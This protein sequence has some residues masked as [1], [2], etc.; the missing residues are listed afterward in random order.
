MYS[1]EQLQEKL[2]NFVEK[3][4][5]LHQP[6]N[7]YEP[8]Q[9]AMHQGGKRVRPLMVLIAADMFSN[10]IEQAQYPAQAIELLHNFTLIHD[11]IM[12][13]APLRRGKPT[14]YQKY[15]TNTAILSADVTCALAYEKLNYCDKEKIPA[16]IKTLTSIF[17]KVCEGQ[18]LDMDF[19]KRTDV[20]AKEYITMISLKT[21]F[22]IAGALKLGAIV[23]N[24]SAQNINTL[25]EIGLYM[26]IAFQLQD[27]V[28]D[29]WSDLKDFGKVAGTDIADNKKTMLY[30]NTLENA[31]EQD[32]QRLLNLYNTT[33][34]NI[35][36]KIKEVKTLF[37]KYDT[38]TK[39]E[40]MANDYIQK[41]LNCLNDMQIDADRKDNLHTLIN[42]LL[43]RNK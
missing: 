29:V 36:E 27:D 32:K 10:D 21:G 2:D 8:V 6:L 1:F 20:T 12:D 37:E 13:A 40:T 22:L 38:K 16:L 26:G 23:G 15:G 17:V 14:L 39:V 31:N 34:S 28:L 3:M 9:Y 24:A 18:A 33:S 35:G 41:A 25:A 7:L 5:F 43:K 11:D 30:I 4:D 19:E 42:Q